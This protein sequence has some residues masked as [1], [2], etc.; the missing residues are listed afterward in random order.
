MKFLSLILLSG[1]ISFPIK[2]LWLSHGLLENSKLYASIEKNPVAA[3]ILGFPKNPWRR[4]I[5]MEKMDQLLQYYDPSIENNA[6]LKAA[7]VL[8]DMEIIDLLLQDQRVENL[9]LH[10]RRQILEHAID[11]DS[12]FEQACSTGN[13]NFILSYLLLPDLRIDSNT[14]ARGLEIAAKGG[15]LNIIKLLINYADLNGWIETPDNN[16]IILAAAQ[17]HSEVVSFLLKWLDPSSKDNMAL[18]MASFNNHLAVVNILLEDPRVDPTALGNSAFLIAC[19]AGHLEIVD[20]LLQDERIVPTI[21][22]LKD[23]YEEH[24]Y[25]IVDMICK[26]LGLD[27][28]NP[29]SWN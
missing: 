15:K 12:P 17:G 23:A 28:G 25:E 1:C 18:F 22:G 9:I 2:T 11:E 13:S 20:R 16:P 27:P 24:H 6:A 10:Y 19:Y 21:M 4:K 29:E 14:I 5:W 26:R 7:V 8:K 3:L